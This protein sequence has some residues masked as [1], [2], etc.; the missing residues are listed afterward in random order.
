[1]S[2]K[3]Q[4]AAERSA[5]IFRVSHSADYCNRADSFQVFSRG[6]QV[7]TMEELERLVMREL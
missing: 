5:Q 7:T 2:P 3:T 1:M 6:M 4:V